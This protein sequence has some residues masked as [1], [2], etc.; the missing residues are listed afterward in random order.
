MNI[1]SLAQSTLLIKHELK[2]PQLTAAKI[3]VHFPGSFTV[4][5]TEG[6][7]TLPENGGAFRRG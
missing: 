7:V 1:V 2:P 5:C 6:S 4:L 3:L